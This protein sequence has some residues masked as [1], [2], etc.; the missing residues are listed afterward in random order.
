[1][2]IHKHYLAL[3]EKDRAFVD[4]A[5]ERIMDIAVER[6]ISLMADDR[7]ERA[8]EALARAVVESREATQSVEDAP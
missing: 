6:G 7:I 3:S 8:V 5:F 1:M 2:S 4:E